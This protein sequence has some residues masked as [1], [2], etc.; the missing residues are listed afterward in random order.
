MKHK[1]SYTLGELAKIL[2]LELVGDDRCVIDGLATLKSAG[3]GKLSFL[4]N[5]A[6]TEQL[7]SCRAS[8]VIID[9]KFSDAFAGNK[10]LS[11]Q[12]YLSYSRATEIFNTK[13][14]SKPSI[15]ISAIVD[16]SAKI[17]A[18]VSIAA[19]AVVSADCV[20]G[21]GC[22]IGAGSIISEGC[23]LG[24]NCE[25]YA[26]VTLYHGITLGDRVIVHSGV[27][28]GADGFGFAFDGEKSVKIHQLGSVRIGDDVEIGAGTTIDR[29]AIED[30]IIEQGVKIDNQVQIGHNCKIGAHSVICGATAIAGSFTMGKY[31]TMGGASGAL[32]HIS[33]ADNVQVSAMSLISQSVKEAGM[34]SSGTG[35]MKTS[36]WKRNIVR[37]QQLDSLAKRVKELEKRA[38]KVKDSDAT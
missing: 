33:I 30:T 34:Y 10:L 2:E 7:S 26:N 5:P 37:F 35:Q 31:C 20:I 1:K 21:D 18:S 38:D 12:P 14:I 22:A 3:A 36:D 25:L 24:E 9:P 8:V 4:S 16:D 11:T 28:L 19:N 6:Y 15:H 17:G 29:G 32:G 27:V 13:P 23:S